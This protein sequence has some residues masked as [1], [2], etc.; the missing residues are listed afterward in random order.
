V[1]GAG[2]QFKVLEAMAC[3]TPVVASRQAVSALEAVDGE[4]LL[5]AEDAA[6]FAQYILDLFAEQALQRRLGTAG[7]RY[8]E[9]HHDWDRIA[10][11]LEQIYTELKEDTLLSL[12]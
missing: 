11:R 10:G 8:V 12:R 9:Q 6:T 4:H 3:A 5:V 1:Y 2:S 7:R